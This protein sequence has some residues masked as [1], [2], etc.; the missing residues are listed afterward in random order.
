[1]ILDPVKLIT[2]ASGSEAQRTNNQMAG[3]IFYFEL[4]QR[5]GKIYYIVGG[6]YKSKGAIAACFKI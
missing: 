5:K 3:Y 1:M 2:L 6:N 4:Y